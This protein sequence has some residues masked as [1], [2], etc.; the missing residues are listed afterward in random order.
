M[1]KTVVRVESLDL[2][3]KRSQLRCWCEVEG[4]KVVEGEALVYVPSRL[5][6]LAAE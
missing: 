4:K 3:K 2:S 6:D 1:V 5:S